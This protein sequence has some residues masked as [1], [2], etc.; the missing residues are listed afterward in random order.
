MSPPRRHRTRTG[1][2]RARADQV[3]NSGAGWRRTSSVDTGRAAA[4]LVQCG[5]RRR[6]WLMCG[7]QAWQR[8][9]R[10]Q[11]RNGSVRNPDSAAA[12][13]WGRMLGHRM[14]LGGALWGIAAGHDVS[15]SPPPG[16]IDRLSFGVVL[17][18][19][20]L[21]AVYK[22]AFYGFVIPALVLAHLPRGAGR[23][24]GHAFTALVMSV[25]LGVRARVRAAPQ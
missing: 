21:T 7:S 25:V 2:A 4:V 3:E 18:G 9:T 5:G 13:R 24:P 16:A 17:G 20:N 12:P 19:L 10:R 14:T 15:G 22:P 11:L 8:V 1:R 23:R 6:R